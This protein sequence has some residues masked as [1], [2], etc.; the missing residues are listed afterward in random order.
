MDPL[1]KHY[2]GVYDPES[3][4]L[5]LVQVRKVTIRGTLRSSRVDETAAEDEDKPPTVR[6]LFSNCHVLA[7]TIL[8]ARLSPPAQPSV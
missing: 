1:L 4:E 6:S 5:Q 2:V 3:G 7:L 8:S